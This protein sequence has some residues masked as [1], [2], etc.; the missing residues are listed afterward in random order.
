M[1]YKLKIA[2]WLYLTVLVI[3]TYLWIQYD[4]EFISN[5][6]C[7]M[8]AFCAAGLSLMLIFFF[9]VRP[10]RPV[11]LANSMAIILIPLFAVLSIV[12]HVFVFKDGFQNKT[13]I[14]WF[15]TAGM[16]YFSGYLYKVLRKHE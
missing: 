8:I 2:D 11:L 16:I 14:L 3:L 1:F 9:L 6:N 12:L 13:V 4:Q 5:P 10:A 15:L 7:R